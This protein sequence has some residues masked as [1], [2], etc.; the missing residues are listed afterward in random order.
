MIL[1]MWFMNTAQRLVGG[2][3]ISLKAKPNRLVQVLKGL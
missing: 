1:I 3:A 2:T